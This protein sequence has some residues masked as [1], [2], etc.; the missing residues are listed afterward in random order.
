[1]KF[2]AFVPPG[3]EI[4]QTGAHLPALGLL[5]L[6]S[7][8]EECDASMKGKIAYFD[9]EQ[10]GLDSCRF[11]VV[12]FLS[13]AKTGIVMLTTYTMTHHRQI[14]FFEEM[15]RHGI[16]TIAG[17]PHVTIHPETSNA[18]YIASS[19]HGGSMFAPGMI[20]ANQAHQIQRNLTLQC[21]QLHHL[22]TTFFQPIASHKRNLANL[23][24]MSI[25]LSCPSV[26]FAHLDH[27]TVGGGLLR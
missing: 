9:E 17:G 24:P 19:F 26:I 7:A 27:K 2:Q 23:R 22:H 4:G 13:G 10:L 18:D 21:G 16:L 3:M 8:I 12:K 20:R 25:L 1:M 6:A 11:E 15:K 14:E 5:M